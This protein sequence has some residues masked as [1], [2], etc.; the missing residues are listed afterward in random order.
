MTAVA[1]PT[2][3]VVNQR[4]DPSP[5]EKFPRTARRGTKEAG[6]PAVAALLVALMLPRGHGRLMLQSRNPAVQPKIELNYRSDAED[7]RRL[8]A[9]VR[10]AWTVLKSEPM[11]NAYQRIA[12]LSEMV[13]G[14]DEQLKSYMRANSRCHQLQSGMVLKGKYGSHAPIALP[15][16][17]SRHKPVMNSRFVPPFTCADLQ[18]FTD[19]LAFIDRSSI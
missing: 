6:V 17:I 15:A 5:G 3:S 12:G 4:H 19:V 7:E 13:V 16:E 11:A 1:R 10:F 8:M 2:R 14:S 9:G 18:T